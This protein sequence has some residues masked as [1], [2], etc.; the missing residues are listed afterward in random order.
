MEP[1]PYNGGPPLAL[2]GEGVP[3][4]PTHWYVITGLYMGD[5]PFAEE[6]GV[7]AGGR[8]EV[9]RDWEKWRERVVFELGK[10][11]IKN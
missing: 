1:F 10:T 7:V 3:I 6:G 11:F 5:L 2:I 4:L 8:G 9:W